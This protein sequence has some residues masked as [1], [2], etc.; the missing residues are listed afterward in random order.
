MSEPASNETR[1]PST[2]SAPAAEAAA[3][4]LLEAM[5]AHV[6]GQREACELLLATYMARGHAL[7]E[8]IPGI[9]KTLLAR[10]FA[11]AL[12]LEFHRVQFTP[13]LMPT[14]VVGTHVFDREGGSFRLVEGP[15]F[16]QVL[17]ADEINRTPPKTQSALLEA[18]QEGQVTIDGDG[19]T[20]DP[21]FFVI[22]TQN[23]VELEGTYP[24]P[25]AQLDRFHARIV[26]SLPSAEAEMELFRRAV[27]GSGGLAYETLPE[28]VVT[29][30]EAAELRRASARVHVSDGLLDYLAR[31]AAAVRDSAH[32]ELAVSPRGAL[33]LLETARAL[34][35]LD[36]R[37]YVTPDDFK[38]CLGPC[39][40]HR[41]I[42]NAE[43]EL[44]G[45]SAAGLLD[46]VA[47]D[48][49]VPK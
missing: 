31:L 34:A 22:A 47:A 46:T 30:E 23:P 43:A 26:M 21:S 27:R 4:R 1:P 35:L 8:G 9:G 10:T 15:I 24:L 7:L 5:E 20:L 36:E 17:M 33:A 32:L 49:E 19:H 25:E 37:D 40:R 39:W 42:L 41:L 12:G 6:L 45:H 48:V 29:A 14:D 3:T 38:R 16:T 28:P 18:M 44:E 13:D 11:S 2:D